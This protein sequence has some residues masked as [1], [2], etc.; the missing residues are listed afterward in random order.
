MRKNCRQCGEKLCPRHGAQQQALLRAMTGVQWGISSMPG[1][2]VVSRLAAEFLIFR[3]AQTTIL[4]RYHRQA[5][6]NPGGSE[7][8]PDGD[9]PSW[10]RPLRPP[11]PA[12]SDEWVVLAARKSVLEGWEL[13]CRQ[14]N[15]NA[16]R[17]Y[18]W[19]T[20]H[21]M[22]PIGGRCYALKGKAYAG[23]WCYEIG[24]GERVYYRPDE[25]RREVVVYYAGPHPAKVPYP[26]AG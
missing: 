2:R 9:R 10:P 25:T 13:L 26:P 12:E 3:H 19:L 18:E 7:T 11:S 22:R 21:P 1:A 6:M 5:S 24:S 15:S 8:G 4:R 14:M 20:R 16:Q 23:C 17:C